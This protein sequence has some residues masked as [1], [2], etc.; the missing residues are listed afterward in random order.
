ML[1]K[2]IPLVMIRCLI[3]TIIIECSFAYLL[4]VNEK[5]DL[6]NVILVNVITNP[7]V[8]IIPIYLGLKFGLLYRNINL[9]IL[10]IL[11]IIIEG[12]CY[13]KN[14]NFKKMNPFLLSFI[15]NFLSY[16]IGQII[17]YWR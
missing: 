9:I 1:I 8:V 15:L 13:K 16:C 6:I 7:I 3:L 14:L 2:D 12:L 11:T 4:K 10:E 5:K 17:N